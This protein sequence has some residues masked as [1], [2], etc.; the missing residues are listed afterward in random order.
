MRGIDAQ[1]RKARE[2][3]LQVEDVGAVG[4]RESDRLVSAEVSGNG[5]TDE[6]RNTRV[7]TVEGIEIW[8]CA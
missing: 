8:L 5:E 7:G 2:A 4:E 1:M 3:L 6:P